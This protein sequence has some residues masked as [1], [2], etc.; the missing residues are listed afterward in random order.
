MIFEDSESLRVAA[1][2][3]ARKYWAGLLYDFILYSI[4]EYFEYDSLQQ[5]SQKTDHE[6]KKTIYTSNLELEFQS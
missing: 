5:K 1:R 4:L 6:K 3:M 2:M